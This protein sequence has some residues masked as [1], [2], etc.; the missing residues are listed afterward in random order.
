MKED[1]L[2]AVPRI[3]GET[4]LVEPGGIGDSEELKVAR[5]GLR[6]EVRLLACRCNDEATY[7]EQY[8]SRDHQEVASQS[9][10]PLV[11]DIPR[12]TSTVAA[13]SFSMRSSA[14]ASET[15][16]SW[17]NVVAK[18]GLRVVNINAF[19]E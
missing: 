19:L 9:P 8:D 12:A 5:H 13:A 3:Y 1:L 4:V 6:L 7:D 17:A 15:C 10:V 14:M 2:R 11:F 18:Y 16:L